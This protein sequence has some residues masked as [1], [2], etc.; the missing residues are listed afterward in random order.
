MTREHRHRMLGVL[1]LARRRAEED[2]REALRLT[3]EGR[4]ER[5]LEAQRSAREVEGIAEGLRAAL[6]ATGPVP[7]E[8]SEPPRVVVL[9]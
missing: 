2:S 6:A 1:D 9:R 4:A 3:L 5:A 7:L 8:L